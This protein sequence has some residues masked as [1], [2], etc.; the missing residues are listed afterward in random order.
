MSSRM[1]TI[2][3]ANH[4]KTQVLVLSALL[5][6]VSSLLL[7]KAASD[8]KLGNQTKMM[9]QDPLNLYV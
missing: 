5:K 1:V 6:P 7:A 4:Q 8:R 9:F 3:Q 2:F